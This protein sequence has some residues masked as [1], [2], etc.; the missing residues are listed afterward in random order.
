MQWNIAFTAKGAVNKY[1][2]A[3]KGSEVSV[4]GG[5]LTGDSL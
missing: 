4:G 5:F 1:A 3:I 2:L